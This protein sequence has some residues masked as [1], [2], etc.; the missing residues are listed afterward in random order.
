MI[1]ILVRFAPVQVSSLNP[2]GV[3]YALLSYKQTE[4]VDHDCCFLCA[5][6][7][8]NNLRH[9]FL[10]RTVDLKLVYD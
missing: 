2:K 6:V 3:L 9:D 4:V 8:N 1:N 7:T 10:P 5:F